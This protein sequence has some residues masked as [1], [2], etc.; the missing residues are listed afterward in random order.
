MKALAQRLTPCGI[1]LLSFLFY[2]ASLPPLGLK[3]LVFLAPAIWVALAVRPRD[4]APGDLPARKSLFLLK[5]LARGE[6]RQY[7]FAC[8]LFGLVALFWVGYPHPMVRLGWLALA[9]YLAI[10]FPLFIFQ[11]RVMNRVARIPL[12]IAATI[13][14]LSCEAFRNVVMGG[15][16]FAGLSHALYD[17]PIFLQLAEVGGEYL[18]GAWIALVGAMLGDAFFVGRGLPNGKKRAARI[19]SV[20]VI[21]FLVNGVF[22]WS[23]INTIDE[24][25]YEMTNRSARPLRV[26]LLQDATQYKYPLARAVNHAVSDRYLALAAETLDRKDDPVDVVVWPEG[27]YYGEYD[28]FFDYPRSY[29]PLYQYFDET[30]VNIDEYDEEY[31]VEN[32]ENDENEKRVYVETV[33][34]SDKLRNDFREFF[35]APDKYEARKNLFLARQATRRQR[36]SLPLLAARLRANL[37]LGYATVEPMLDGTVKYYNSAIYVP[38]P[39]D[40]SAAVAIPIER[41]ERFPVDAEIDDAPDAFRRYDKVDLVMFGEYVPFVKY[42]PKSWNITSICAKFTL[43]RGRGPTDVAVRTRDGKADFRLAPQ[44]CFESSIPHYVFDQV[45]RL[46]AQGSDPDALVCVSNDGW[47]HCGAETDL[48][49]ATQVFRAIENRRSLLA[50]THGGFSAWI[51]AAGRIREKGE[52]GVSQVVYA[53]VL[54]AK[55]RPLGLIRSASGDVNLSIVVRNAGFVVLAINL[56]L[57]IGAGLRRKRAAQ[58]GSETQSPTN[59][60]V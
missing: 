57:A 20:A 43:S 53:D 34:P 3:Y 16:S 39:G 42:L 2:Y 28:V 60:N 22:G 17:V 11:T 56:C 58:T 37:L 47:F 55:S 54:C 59:S 29:E 21:L 1:A 12:P 33:P 45:A 46:K 40:E 32:N 51:D 7:W 8:F 14:Y 23:R 18:V 9:A 30:A 24:L 27:T 31:D 13:A 15:F 44:I 41:L 49:L 10:Y 19:A 36:R 50:A 48:H 38:N 5:W 52:R 25:E 35:E 6:Y 4:A 26:A